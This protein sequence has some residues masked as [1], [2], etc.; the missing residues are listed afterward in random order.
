[1]LHVADLLA[2]GCRFGSSGSFV[3]PELDLDSWDLLGLSPNALDSLIL[4]A[5]RQIREVSGMFF[6]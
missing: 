4:Q 6:G 5:E 2:L 1:M 3:I